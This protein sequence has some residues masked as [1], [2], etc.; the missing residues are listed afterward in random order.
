[1]TDE[2][3]KV[4]EHYGV[5]GMKWGVRKDRRTSR[6]DRKWKKKALS[7]K[8]AASLMDKA[9]PKIEKDLVALKSSYGAANL[10]SDPQLKKKYFNES[11]E[12]F[13]KHLNAAA[14]SVGTN[15][16]GTK[17]LTAS[18]TPDGYLYV[19]TAK[20]KHADD[21]DAEKFLLIRDENGYITGVEPV[22]EVEEILA[23]YGVKGMKWGVRKSRKQ[24]RREARLR[25]LEEKS[26]KKKINASEDAKTVAKL[27]KKKVSELSNSEL[28]LVA[29]RLN[30]ETKLNKVNQ[31]YVDSG[32]AKLKKAV[33][34]GETLERAH[35]LTTSEAG[36]SATRKGYKLLQAADPA[37]AAKLRKLVKKLA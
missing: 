16:S 36:K 5:K 35:R 20:I 28:K 15:P 26:A 27:R 30:L 4:L 11:Q 3:D 19:R 33:S 9:L 23:H 25:R 32:H 31:S 21:E 12:I 17:K 8:T 37:A 29:E 13:N 6:G 22:E 7:G 18:I 34:V 24:R 2:L 1:M 10:S 14:G